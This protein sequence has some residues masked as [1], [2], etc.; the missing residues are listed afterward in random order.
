MLFR[1]LLLR[2]HESHFLVILGRHYLTARIPDIWLAVI[3]FPSSATF[4]EPQCRKYIVDRNNWG[5]ASQGLFFSTFWL[6]R[7]F[8]HSTYF[9][10]H[11]FPHF[12]MF[13]LPNFDFFFCNTLLLVTM[14]P[15]L[16]FYY[17][18]KFLLVLMDCRSL[19]I[20]K[21]GKGF[22]IYK[23]PLSVRNNSRCSVK[24]LI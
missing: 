11:I 8:I 4:S 17:E 3:P 14:N 16:S 22:N 2:F 19:W 13:V 7:L 9:F 5:W 1:K 23:Q 6:H 15:L 12:W 18:R 20:T 10:G 21:C 24:Y